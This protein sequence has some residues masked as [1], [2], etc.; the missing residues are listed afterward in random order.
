MTQVK[1][2]WNNKMYFVAHMTNCTVTLWRDDG[3][4]FTI[5]INEYKQ[6][7]REVTG[8]GKQERRNPDKG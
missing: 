4:R 8:N 6:N 3:S 5:S 2:K 1:N 7:Y